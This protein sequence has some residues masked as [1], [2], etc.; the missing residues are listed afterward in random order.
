[1]ATPIGHALAGYAVHGL[2]YHQEE[3][4]YTG[5]LWACLILAII[6]DLDF[7]PG[8]VQGQ[9][10]L[11]HQGIS[12]SFIFA[13]IISLFAAVLYRLFINRKAS[14]LGNL[15]LFCL[16][17]SSHLVIDLFGPDAR[18]PY[19]IPSFWPFSSDTYLSPFQIFWGVQHAHTTTTATIEWVATV[20]QP[21]NLGAIAIEVFVILPFLI[22]LK[23]LK[24]LAHNNQHSRV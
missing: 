6:P 13:G 14:F 24:Y 10:A 20:L 16:A 5:V 3:E 21:Y 7:L 11:Y 23:Y 8:I 17:Y 22:L 12:H 2:G 15:V 1:M 18:P 9:P 4:H 19:C